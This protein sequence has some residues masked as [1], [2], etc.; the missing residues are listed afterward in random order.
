MGFIKWDD[1]YR[2]RIMFWV[3]RYI[4]VFLELVDIEQIPSMKRIHI[5]LGSNKKVSLEM[6]ELPSV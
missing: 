1:I 4:H 2:L 3:G 6:F 5:S